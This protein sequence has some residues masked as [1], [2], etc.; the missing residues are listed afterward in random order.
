MC[1]GDMS[2]VQSVNSIEGGDENTNKKN[3]WQF[4]YEHS[5]GVKGKPF[6][7]TTYSLR[8]LNTKE[9]QRFCVYTRC[10][11]A[12]LPAARVGLRHHRACGH[13]KQRVRKV[14]DDV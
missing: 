5:P 4:E 13:F 3:E 2:N 10:C 8:V 1:G 14:F 12:A 7:K 6:N 9:G 11:A